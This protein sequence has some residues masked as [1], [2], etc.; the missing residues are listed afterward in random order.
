MLITEIQRQYSKFL[1]ILL[2]NVLNK[3]ETETF[4]RIFLKKGLPADYEFSIKSL[5]GYLE[6]AYGEKGRH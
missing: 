2:M 1:H 3:E 5:C 4:N 6:K